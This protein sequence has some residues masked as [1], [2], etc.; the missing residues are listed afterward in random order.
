MFVFDAVRSNAAPGTI[1][2]LNV[3]ETPPPPDWFIH[4]SHAFG[5]AEALELGRQMNRLPTEMIVYGISGRNFELGAAI[6]EEVA[7]ACDTVF[8]TARD[9]ILKRLS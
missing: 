9:E 7:T 5:L 8:S 4:S 3:L 6:S 1:H 2:R